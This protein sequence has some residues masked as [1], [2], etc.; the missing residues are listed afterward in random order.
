METFPLGPHQ[1]NQPQELLGVALMGGGPLQHQRILILFLL[2]DLFFATV[3]ISQNRQREQSFLFKK[4]ISKLRNVGT[5]KAK[6]KWSSRLKECFVRM[7][8]DQFN[9]AAIRNALYR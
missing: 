8:E 2:P 5:D 7:R 6:I 9:E 3:I 1:I 4:P